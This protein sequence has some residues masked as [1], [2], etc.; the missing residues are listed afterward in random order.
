MKP[1]LKEMAEIG[2]ACG[3]VPPDE[4]GAI[5]IQVI[6]LDHEQKNLVVGESVLEN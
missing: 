2:K 3:V 5:F 1:L 4:L 6:G